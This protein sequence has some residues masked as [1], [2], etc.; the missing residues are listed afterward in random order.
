MLQFKV[1]ELY[2]DLMVF[3]DMQ[4][5]IMAFLILCI[6]SRLGLAYLAKNLS[7]IW[8]NIITAVFAI[9]GA[10]FLVIYFG[11]LRKTGAETGGNPIWWNHLR[12]IHGAL[13]LI[14][15]GLLF[16]GHRCWG[17]QVIII[18]TLVGLTSFL[19]FHLREGNI[20]MF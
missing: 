8:S 12:P 14:A 3:E 11:G 5:R 19:L 4:K 1:F 16:Y 13:Y 2:I 6:G 7:G 17:S 18:D 10:G 9:I 15:A 20:K